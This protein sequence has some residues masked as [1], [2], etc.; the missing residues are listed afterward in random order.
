[1]AA[2][3]PGRVGRPPGIDGDDT[4]EGI[5]DAARACFA[6]QGYSATTNR[7]IADRA[8]LTAAAVYHHFGKKPD[9][10]VAVHRANEERYMGRILAAVG[11][12]PGFQAKLAALL[13]VIH[14][15]MRDDPEMVTFYAVAQDEARRHPELKAIEEDRTFANL[16][17]D[18][19]DSGVR[20]G[21]IAP[22]DVSRARGAI[23]AVASGL[24]L[25]SHLTI[26]AH[27]T[28]TEGA[29]QLLAGELMGA[30]RR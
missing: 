8:G 17:V 3:T 9:L 14:E 21:V 26:E 16:F 2:R 7:M 13:D 10:M 11:E 6:S 23:V 30:T 20:E 28:A 15:T 12:P 24:A 19:V 27:R 22:Q 4:R 25:M 18:L 29:K 5:L 1:M